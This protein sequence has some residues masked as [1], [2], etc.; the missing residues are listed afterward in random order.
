M[1]IISA[2]LPIGMPIVM[3]LRPAVILN[4]CRIASFLSNNDTIVTETVRYLYIAMLSELF[5]TWAAIL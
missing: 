2:A 3:L 4:A 1:P 5:M